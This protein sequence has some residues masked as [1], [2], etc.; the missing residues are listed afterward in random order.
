MNLSSVES[1]ENVE[2]SL[3]RTVVVGQTILVNPRR[4]RRNDQVNELGAFVVA[5]SITTLFQWSTLSTSPYDELQLL[6]STYTERL[7]LP[8]TFVNLITSLFMHC[9]RKLKSLS[10]N[11]HSDIFD[12][13]EE[14]IKKYAG[15]QANCLGGGKIEHD[16]DEKIIRVYG[17]SQ[18]Y[19]KADHQVSIELLKK[20]YP[21][22]NITCDEVY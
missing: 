22:Y 12:E 20:K 8:C 10:T 18:G 2:A 21:D 3:V 11:E 1:S 7:Y 19:G 14:Q 15:L 6:V 9:I 5:T 16:P 13:V 17:S 4:L